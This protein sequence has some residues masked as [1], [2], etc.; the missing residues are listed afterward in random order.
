M[1]GSDYYNDLDLTLDHA[2]TLI[3]AGAKN[4][5]SPFH[6]PVV[7]TLGI[8]G[9]P[10]GRILVL[11]N[12]DRDKREL[13]FNT[14]LRSPKVAEIIADPRMSVLLYD[15]EAKIQLRLSGLARV[16]SQG[17]EVD[18]I[19][20]AA[21]RFSRRCYM[22][23]AAPSSIIDHPTSGLPASVAG[24]K[25]EEVELIPARKNF[26][27]LLFE[28]QKIDWLYLATEGHRRAVFHYDIVAAQ[29]WLGDWAIP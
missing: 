5:R 17:A 21:D 1:N 12:T 10:Q 20:L 13:R 11:R 23:E 19:W 29:S 7:S 26:A 24:R 6:T 14:D 15:A 9:A 18:T 25:P 8:D 3:E 4:R 16:Q 28:V 27:L 22:A 2:W